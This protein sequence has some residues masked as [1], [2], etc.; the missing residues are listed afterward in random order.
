M[1]TVTDGDRL[2]LERMNTDERTPRALTLSVRVVGAL[3]LLAMAGIHL[4]LWVD[5][6]RDIPWIGPLFLANVVLGAGAAVAVLVTPRRWFPWVALLAG[7]LSLSTLGGLVLS[8]TVG[9][10]GY[11]EVVA[12]YVV[13]TILVESA[14]FL[15][16]A[17]DGAYELLRSRRRGHGAWPWAE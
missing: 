9:L 16:L 4:K 3:L 8:L 15:V 13:P 1:R 11:H 6:F 5:G 10:F 12:G 14:A 17:G 7:L 2:D